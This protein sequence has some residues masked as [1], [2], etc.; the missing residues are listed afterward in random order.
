[1]S[2]ASAT[3]QDPWALVTLRVGT[4]TRVGIL[5]VAGGPVRLPAELAG[6]AGVMDVVRQWG[7]MEPALRR[8]TTQDGEPVEDAELLTP[9][10]FPP[11]VLCSGPN[12]HDHLAEMGQSGLGD[13]WTAYFFFKPPTTTLIGP[14]DPVLVG[15]GWEADRFDWEG[16]LA[17][18]MA[19]GGRDI[20]VADALSHAAGYS[21]A[22]DIS[23]RGPHRRDTPAAPFV[24]DWVAS[25]AA[26]TSLPLGP[27]L[28][29]T[30]HL[31][32]TSALSIRTLVNGTIKQDGST[33]SMVLDVAQLIAG[34]SRL[35]TLEPG[36]VI[37]TGTP[38]GVG[39]GRGELLRPGDL[40]EVEIA[41]VGRLA[42]RVRLRDEPGPTT[43]TTTTS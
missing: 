2:D 42:N 21:V 37:V 16:E 5:P 12:Y 13:A 18:V 35:L 39:A 24:W 10:R 14:T 29:P 23:L 26:D 11:K 32:D 3:L 6:C 36:D 28:V 4:S 41:G 43:P 33:S 34:A 7:T 9:L 1:M 17:V 31:P 20:A 40:V 8:L 38:A 27:G 19:R 15:P 30:W 25:K 22:N